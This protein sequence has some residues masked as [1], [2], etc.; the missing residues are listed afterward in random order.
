MSVNLDLGDPV[1]LTCAFLIANWSL[2]PVQVA[3]GAER[4]GYAGFGNLRPLI[5]PV[6]GVE[7]RRRTKELLVHTI[8]SRTAILCYE[9]SFVETPL[10][11]FG[12]YND[13]TS[14]VSM[15]MRTAMGRTK[16]NQLDNEAR[17]VCMIYRKISPGENWSYIKQVD[18]RNLTDKRVGLF[19]IVRD[20]QFIKSTDYVGHQ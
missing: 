15:D 9:A 16:L 3:E 6:E 7:G 2:I 19:R 14:R 20:I 5:E 11:V 10:P 4:G 17:R 1:Q 18:R 12:K 8:P 13:V